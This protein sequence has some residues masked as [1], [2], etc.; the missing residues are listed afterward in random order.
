MDAR[1]PAPPPPPPPGLP[2]IAEDCNEGA[3]P[4]A[5][6]LLPLE[7][8]SFLLEEDQP[9]FDPPPPLPG[10]HCG[11]AYPLDPEQQSGT[12]AVPQPCAGGC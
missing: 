11:P 2:V 3:E 10:P 5:E 7:L 4:D 6:E 12:L 1:R 8:P 9:G